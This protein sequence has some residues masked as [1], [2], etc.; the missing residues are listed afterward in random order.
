M[1][2]PICHLIVAPFDRE[3]VE[4]EGKVYHGHCLQ[5]HQIVFNSQVKFEVYVP[6][7]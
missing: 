7:H 5:S 4:K 3:K 1:Y 2:C 6:K